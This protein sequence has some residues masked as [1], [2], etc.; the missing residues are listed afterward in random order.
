MTACGRPAHVDAVGVQLDGR[1][2]ER[3][4]F[5]FVAVQWVG[6]QRGCAAGVELGDGLL[7][8]GGEG[9]VAQFEITSGVVFGEGLDGG[10][11]VDGVADVVGPVV[12]VGEL[13]GGGYVS[14]GV[15][16][17]GDVWGLVGELCCDVSEFGEDG[18][19]QGRVEGAAGLQAGGFDVLVAVVG[20]QFGD[21]VGVS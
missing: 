2:D 13:V 19:H 1:G 5:G 4:G 12:G 21:G 8:D 11:V 16:E 18:V 17:D 7:G 15:G 6:E 3:V 20:F 9:G 10:V 14:G